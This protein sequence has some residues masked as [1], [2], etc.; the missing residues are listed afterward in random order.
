M[1]ERTEIVLNE[2]VTVEPGTVVSVH[3]QPYGSIVADGSVLTVTPYGSNGIASIPGTF[4]L[5]IPAGSV[6]DLAGNIHHANVT[7]VVNNVAPAAAAD[8]Y[9]TNQ[10]VALNVDAPGVLA[11]DFD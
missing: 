6:K 8:A 9:T 7:L 11:N 3:G 1:P 2:A 4:V 10:G 5:S